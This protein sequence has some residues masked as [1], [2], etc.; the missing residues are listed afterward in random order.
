MSLDAMVWVLENSEERLGRRLVLL[1]LADT[2]N[3]SG[4]ST[5]PSQETLARKARLS[6]RQVRRALIDLSNAG[7]IEYVGLSRYGTDEW[8]VLMPDKLSD[9]DKSN[10]AGGQIGSEDRTNATG[11]R[12]EMSDK[13]SSKQLPKQSG[14]PATSS[15][16]S[17]SKTKKDIPAGFAAFWDRYPRR[18]GRQEAIDAYAKRL[19][20]V[21]APTL[22][23]GLDRWKAHWQAEETE[24]KFIPHASRWL[25]RGDFATPPP[26]PTRPFTQ[27]EAE[28]VRDLAREL[29]DE[30]QNR[31]RAAKEYPYD[32]ETLKRLGA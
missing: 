30:E 7:A 25:N 6:V 18:I 1:A 13:Q 20:E 26:K 3:S 4:E 32:E 22:L 16:P 5:F 23:D 10:S 15:K 19:D 12:S 24:E 14:K 28:A 31:R 29:S 27:T 8:R 2:A 17:S 11:S 9:A 21:G